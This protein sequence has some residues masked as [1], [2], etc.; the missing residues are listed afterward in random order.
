MIKHL[1]FYACNKPLYSV[2]QR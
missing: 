2:G 1:S